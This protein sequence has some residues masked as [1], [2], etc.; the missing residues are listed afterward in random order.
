MAKATTR[1]RIM[2]CLFC[3]NLRNC[4][5]ELGKGTICSWCFHLL[6]SADQQYLKQLY[7]NTIEDGNTEKARLLRHFLIFKDAG[8]MN[9]LKTKKSKRNLVRKRPVR[10]VRPARTRERA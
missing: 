9:D 3:S 6:N 5:P 4:I 2:E 1:G 7:G 10:T 8:G